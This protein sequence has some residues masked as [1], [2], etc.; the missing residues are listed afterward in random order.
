MIEYRCCDCDESEVLLE[1][2]P[3][4]ACPECGYWM[5]AI[6]WESE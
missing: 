1:I 2:V 6:E 5:E 4:K 3:K